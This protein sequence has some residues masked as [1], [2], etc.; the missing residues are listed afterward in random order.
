[1]KRRAGNHAQETALMDA[2]GKPMWVSAG[3]PFL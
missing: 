2:A 1:V 3:F